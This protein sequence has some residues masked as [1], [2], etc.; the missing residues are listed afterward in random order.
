MNSFEF[1]FWQILEQFKGSKL[2]NDDDLYDALGDEILRLT[3]GGATVSEFLEAIADDNYL[4]RKGKKY[5]I[6]PKGERRRNILRKMATKAKLSLPNLQ[7]RVATKC[8]TACKS[9][10]E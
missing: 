7:S 3:L 1:S 5:R 6:T 9:I 10:Q 8:R 2:F 4:E